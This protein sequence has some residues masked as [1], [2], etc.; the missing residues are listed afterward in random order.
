MSH[1]CVLGQ[2]RAMF[3]CEAARLYAQNEETDKARRL[4]M[5]A[6]GAV[7]VKATVLKQDH[8]VTLQQF[9]LMASVYDQ[10]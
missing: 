9:M 7:I 5:E 10:G 6:S 4:Y 1:A 3:F 8:D 2:E